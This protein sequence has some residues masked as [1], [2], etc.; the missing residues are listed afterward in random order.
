MSLFL[1]FWG[2]YS[3]RWI[4]NDI[5]R[6]FLLG[7]R[8]EIAKFLMKTFTCRST[9]LYGSGTL[10]GRQCTVPFSVQKW[11]ISRRRCAML[12]NISSEKSKVTRELALVELSLACLMVT[13]K[14][15]DGSSKRITILSILVRSDKLLSTICFCIPSYVHQQLHLLNFQNLA[16]AIL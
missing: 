8:K 9:F 15:Y 5:G 14:F 12:L 11:I 16:H 4:W 1:L 2:K 3:N 6:N 10:T 13:W 7:H